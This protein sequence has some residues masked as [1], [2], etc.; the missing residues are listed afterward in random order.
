MLLR[1][2]IRAVTLGA[3]HPDLSGKLSCPTQQ[4]SSLSDKNI[5]EYGLGALV[6]RMS[7][8]FGRSTKRQ[9]STMISLN[10]VRA[11]FSKRYPS[12]R[13]YIE[14]F[15]P[16]YDSSSTESFHRDA[17]ALML[18]DFHRS[19]GIHNTLEEE[20]LVADAL[21]ELCSEECRFSK[22]H[23]T[24]QCT[25]FKV[26][27]ECLLNILE[28][29]IGVPE[30]SMM[31]GTEQSIIS[32]KQPGRHNALHA[33]AQFVFVSLLVL[34]FAG[35]IVWV[36]ISPEYKDGVVWSSYETEI[37]VVR[38]GAG[39]AISAT[40]FCLLVVN[41]Y[42]L[43]ILLERLYRLF[44]VKLSIVLMHK[45]FAVTILLGG[46]MHTAGWFVFY[47]KLVCLFLRERILMDY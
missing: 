24:Q 39:L 25:R 32:G 33:I 20:G 17:L 23:P 36:M 47:S 5:E 1:D 46:L 42:F 21:I 8:A 45:V 6:N 13:T 16:H 28:S 12:T 11:A 31:E 3:M 19:I 2:P 9:Y 15:Y 10:A 38:V 40:F 26:H 7:R 18:R 41:K 4:K 35:L 30:S 14:S 37:I 27:K 22:Q 43:K 34:G 29:R 44:H